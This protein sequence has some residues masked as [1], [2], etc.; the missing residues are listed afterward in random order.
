MEF[1]LADLFEIVADTVPDRLALVAGE[2]RRTYRELDERATRLAHHLQA[3]GIVAGEHVAVYA[4][5]RAEWLEAEL[6]IYKARAAVINVNYRY[7]ADELAYV[8]ENSDAVAVV[9]E[10]SFA[11][12]L[13][14]V[15]RRVPTL[16]RFVVLADGSTDEESAQA[17][18]TLDAVAYEDALA[19]A[20][21]TRD[22][23][24][25][26]ADDPYILYTGGTT[27]V[28]K[29]V[30]WRA[31]DIFFAALGGGG[32]GQPPIRTAAEL[33]ERVSTD[34]TTTVGVVNAPMMHGGG[35][36]VTFITF[37]GGNTAVL[38]C[39]R[40]Y[41]GDRVLRLAERERA[42]SVMVV[43]DAMARPLADALAAPGAA[44]DLSA[45]AAIGSGGAILSKAVKDE[46]RARLPGVMV[47]DSFGASETGAAGTVLD[48]DGPAAG[49][50]FT[51][52]D[53]VT[54]LDDDGGPVEAGSGRVGRLA[55]RGHI[56]LAYY[57]DPEKTA[58]T[59]VTDRAGARWVVPGD[60]ATIEADGTLNL[61]GRGSVCINTGG[62]K[63]YPEE[64]EATLKAHPDVFDAVVVG[65]PDERFVERVAAI[66]TPRPGTSVT[67]DE[68]QDFCRPKLAAYKMPRQLRLTDEIPRTPVGKP[69][70]RWAK[71][72]ATQP[73]P[74]TAGPDSA[75]A[76][77]PVRSVP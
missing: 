31:E 29:G 13:L 26:S 50:K 68:L 75:P 59:F 70:Y 38:N 14:A 73:G 76:P 57:R 1:N 18:A 20:S 53:W 36:W 16:R 44:Y 4:W 3:A 66:V 35:Q 9:F 69:D 15:R 43:G 17:V 72:L 42:N 65:V 51:V 19:A 71:R 11:P 77:T 28:P 41:D 34:D 46:L 54:V 63:V 64:V 45:L 39:A 49:P 7:V 10:R 32:F 30:V 27:G 62:E 48:F 24:P 52:S 55:R 58:A 33:A 2:E 22:F 61:L 60:Y 40:H 67:L 21:P 6:G 56:P 5:N 74:P 25:R 47:T 23:G 8:L 37:Y 12:L